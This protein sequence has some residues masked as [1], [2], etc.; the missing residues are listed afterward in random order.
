MNGYTYQDFEKAEDKAKFIQGAISVHQRSDECRTAVI[1]DLYDRQ[2]N[3]TVMEYSQ[4]L[5]T[6]QGLKVEDFTAANNKIAS[7]FF[8]RLNTQRVS[9]SLGN[10]ISFVQPDEP[11]DQEDK[12]KEALGDDIDHIIFEAAYY[13][14]THG[15]SFCFWNYDHVHLFKLTEFVPLY[16]ENDGTL[17]AGI[18]FWQL[19]KNKPLNITL[20]QEDGYSQW[21]QAKG[22]FTA[23]DANGNEANDEVLQAYK[24]TVSYLPADDSITVVGEE[25]YSRLPIVPLWASRLKQS[26]LIGM[27]AAIDAYDLI[28]SGFANDLQ[29]CSVIYWIVKNAGGMTDSDLAKFRDRLKLMHI[30]SID[31]SE[32]AGVE[33]YTQDIPTAARE[34]F[35]TEIRNGIYEDFGALDV[36]TV[37]AGA[38]N[39]HIDAAYQ[40]MEENAADFEYWVAKCIKQI[41]RLAGIEDEPI[42]SRIR[43]SNQKE[44]VEMVVQEAQWLDNATILRKLPN[45]RPDEVAAILAEMNNEDMSRFSLEPEE[46]VI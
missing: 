3:Q 6:A 44:Q 18:R 7:N 43:I 46:E 38:T 8:N 14:C 36:H 1:A 31:N 28:R 40:P 20:Y 35:L 13:A 21:R 16:D 10:G 9:F 27:R 2:M 45:I 26:T 4:M 29:D 23:I 37:S 41:L 12:T 22:K 24:T 30:A 33:P 42:F 5:F 39:D 19:S 11:Q 34:T 32:G 25:N 17:R 15:V